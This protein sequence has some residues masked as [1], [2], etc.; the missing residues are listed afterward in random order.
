MTLHTVTLLFLL[1]FIAVGKVHNRSS[2]IISCHRVQVC[3][4]GN[5]A[6]RH[7]SWGTRS[8]EGPLT[9]Q[10]LQLQFS[11]RISA[12]SFCNYDK[13]FF[14]VKFCRKK[15]KNTGPM[16]PTKCNGRGHAPPVSPWLRHWWEGTK[17]Q[18][19][20]FAFRKEPVTMSEMLMVTG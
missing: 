2:K 18:G 1:S 14:F 12:T 11:P 16:G 8:P 7:L 15:R 6:A 13:T 17:Q 3:D 5:G 20:R 19:E 10:G 4:S 9:S